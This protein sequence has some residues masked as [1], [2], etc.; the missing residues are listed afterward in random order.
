MSPTRRSSHPS[1]W[2]FV[3]VAI[4]LNVNLFLPT[5]SISKAFIDF[6]GDHESYALAYD[7]S[8]G[9]F[10]DIRDNHWK[11]FQKIHAQVF[12]NHFIKPL[13]T[14]PISNAPF[15]YAENFQEEFHCKWG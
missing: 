2:L 9:F 4:L 12:P 7:Q 5:S 14:E 3:S 8:F 10:D 13:S 11:I 6:S 1:V 15:W